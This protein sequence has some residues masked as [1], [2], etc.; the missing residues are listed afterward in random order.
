MNGTRVLTL[1]TTDK[2]N[3][4]ANGFQVPDNDN[5]YRKVERNYLQRTFEENNID[6]IKSASFLHLIGCNSKI[7]LV[8]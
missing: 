8:L 6:S 4:E 1:K 3:K 5:A 2:E 7:M